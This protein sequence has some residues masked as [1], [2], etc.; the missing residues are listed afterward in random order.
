VIIEA[1]TPSG[2]G[3][4]SC[5]TQQNPVNVVDCVGTN[6]TAGGSANFDINVFDTTSAS[7]SGQSTMT[8]N[9]NGT[10]VESDQSNDTNNSMTS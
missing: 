9:P 10:I 6:L 5:Q 8:V 2:T 3:S 4:W 1:V 7:L